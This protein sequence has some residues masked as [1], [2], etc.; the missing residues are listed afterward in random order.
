MNRDNVQ[1]IKKEYKVGTIIEIIAMEGENIPSG[2]KGS[3]QHVDDIG[4]IHMS[5]NNGSS[6]GLVENVDTF[7]IISTPSE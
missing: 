1:R 7:K 2:T 6:L 3:V 5:W 4:T